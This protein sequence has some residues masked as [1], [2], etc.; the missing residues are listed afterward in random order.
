MTEIYLEWIKKAEGDY[1]TALRE[2]RARKD[3]NLDA[4]CFHAQQCIEKYFKA[5]L[6]KKM[7]YFPKTHD[8]NVLLDLIIPFKPLWEVYRNDLKLL[9]GYAVEV[10]YPG[11]AALK[12]D[13]KECIRI[14][15]YLHSEFKKILNL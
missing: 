9:S 15:K 3:P 8:L 10:R 12:E 5:F 13:A 1:N 7:V 6:Q 2:N 4:A 11:E 14:M